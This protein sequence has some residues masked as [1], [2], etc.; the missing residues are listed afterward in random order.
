MIRSRR[1]NEIDRPE[2][3]TRHIDIPAPYNLQLKE[4]R[5]SR[6]HQPGAEVLEEEVPSSDCQRLTMEI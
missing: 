6:R 3:M 4:H 5:T 2:E 1:G